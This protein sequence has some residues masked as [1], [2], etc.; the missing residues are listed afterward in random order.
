MQR[1]HCADDT[2]SARMCVLSNMFINYCEGD[3]NAAVAPDLF[4][5]FGVSPPHDW[6]SYKLWEQPLPAWVME[7]L[8]PETARR[9]LDEKFRVY[10]WLGVK[11]YW[12]HDPSRRWIREGL[13]GYRLS[14]KKVREAIAPRSASH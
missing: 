6:R 1:G 2:A 3:R 9:E 5:A 11:E 12:L 8:S 10:E 13:R 7:V 4:V 14:S